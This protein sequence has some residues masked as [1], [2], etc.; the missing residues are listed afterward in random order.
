MSDYIIIH[1]YIEEKPRGINDYCVKILGECMSTKAAILRYVEDECGGET[2]K[3]F[4]SISSRLTNNEMI[5]L[6]NLM[7]KDEDE[8]VGVYEIAK[9]VY[10]KKNAFY[11]E[12]E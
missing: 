6:Y 4:S 3:T 1:R 10:M 7:L 5:K 12:E 11:L 8:I 2:F 9:E